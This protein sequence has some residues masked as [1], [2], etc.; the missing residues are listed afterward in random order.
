MPLPV[1]DEVCSADLHGRLSAL[2]ERVRLLLGSR[3]SDEAARVL[4]D[5]L[6]ELPLSVVE[7]SANG[8]MDPVQAAGLTRAANALQ[9]EL[10]DAGRLDRPGAGGGRGASGG[11]AGGRCRAAGRRGTAGRAAAGR[12]AGAAGGQRCHRRE[13]STAG[14]QPPGRPPAMHGSSGATPAGRPL[15]ARQPGEPERAARPGRDGITARRPVGYRDF[16]D[17]DRHPR[18]RPCPILTA[19]RS[20]LPGRPAG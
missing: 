20:T 8:L 13:Y 14:R 19:V 9:C 3:L 7:A 17:R 16:V 4:F 2:G 5:D 1:D 11:R 6:G 10:H 15:V 18:H 12:R